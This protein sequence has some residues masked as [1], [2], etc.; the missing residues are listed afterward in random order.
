MTLHRLFPLVG[1]LHVL[2]AK[3]YDDKLLFLCC[4]LSPELTD[5]WLLVVWLFQQGLTGDIP[6]AVRLAHTKRETFINAHQFSGPQ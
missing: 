4:M 5:Y 1:K 6:V 3:H 2:T